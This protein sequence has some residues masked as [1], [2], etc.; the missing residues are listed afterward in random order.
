MLVGEAV[1]TSATVTSLDRSITEM[2]VSHRTPFLNHFMEAVTWAGSWIATLCATVVVIVF[3]W[4]RRISTAAVAAVVAAWVGELTAVSLTKGVVRRPR[5]PEAVRIV[6]AHGWS[7]PSGHSANA[8]V[9][10]AAAAA[11]ASHRVRSRAARALIWALATLATALVG[12]SRIELGVHWMTD[13]AASLVW[14]SVWILIIVKAVLS[15]K[16]M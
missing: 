4:R 14:T 15:Q 3:R 2:V 16:R 6:T 12:F 8:V 7:F 1:K 13:V 11:L 10:F 9:V 5:P